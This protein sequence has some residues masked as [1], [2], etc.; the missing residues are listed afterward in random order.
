MILKKLNC[1]NHSRSFKTDIDDKELY[2]EID[3]RV[4]PLIK[5]GDKP[6]VTNKAG[7]KNMLELTN[8]QAKRTV[9]LTPIEKKV[10]EHH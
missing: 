4:I 3:K 7:I 10:W 8:Q 9:Q 2:I 1:I 6:S 5:Q